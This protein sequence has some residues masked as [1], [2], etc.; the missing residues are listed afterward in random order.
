MAL[1][2][3]R[4]PDVEGS[5]ARAWLCRCTP[6]ERLRWPTALDTWLVQTPGG[7]GW[8]VYVVALITLR[9]VPG[10]PP[11][12][13]SV[14]G[15]THELMVWA[16]DDRGRRVDPDDSDSIAATGRLEPA[17]YGRQFVVTSDV[18]AS[19]LAK[20]MVLAFTAGG[21]PIEPDVAIVESG[22]VVG[23]KTIAINGRSLRQIVHGAIDATAQCIREG[24]HAVQ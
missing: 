7:I 8:S 12:H 20:S 17:N 14:R 6:V 15:A 1:E 11:A 18:Q 3:K 4:T 10:F 16:L 13:R 9:D 21:L 2:A 22:R 5:A 23:M 24:N 19:Q